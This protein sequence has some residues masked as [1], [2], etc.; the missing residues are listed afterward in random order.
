[1]SLESTAGK[2]K[3]GVA[4]GG[5]FSSQWV[6]SKGNSLGFQHASEVGWVETVLWNEP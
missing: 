6:G 2:G 3:F 5:C 4:G 1:M